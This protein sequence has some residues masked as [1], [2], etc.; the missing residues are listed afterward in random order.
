MKKYIVPFL[1]VLLTGCS[2]WQ[3]KPVHY[4]TEEYFQQG[5]ALMAEGKYKKAAEAWEKVLDAYVSPQMNMLAELKIAEAHFLA[6]EYAEAAA[7]YENFLKRHPQERRT[8][9]VMFLLGMCY[10]EQRLP[11][12][13]DQTATYNALV[14]FQSLV[15]NYPLSNKV[16]AAKQK[17]DILRAEMAEHEF[18]V[19][20]FYFRTDEYEAAIN[21]FNQLLRNYPEYPEKGKIFY[22]LGR[23]YME[24]DK[25]QE[26]VRAFDIL[27]KQYPD[28][29]YVAEAED[30]L[31]VKGS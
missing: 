3:Q 16:A 4:S 12:D 18:Y 2:M 22:Y 30:Y 25:S 14:T 24:T 7:A 9:E 21:R 27:L 8:P 15:R 23:A 10:F 28:S 17:I 31:P 26:A 19:A 6:E 13:R 11:A 20:N 1:L 5:E 29:P